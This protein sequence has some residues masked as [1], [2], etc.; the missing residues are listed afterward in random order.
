MKVLKVDRECIEVKDNIR[1][2]MQ[3]NSIKKLAESISEHG[4][5]QPLLV[6]ETGKGSYELIA[7]H[8]RLAAADD[9]S[10]REIP[11]LVQAIDDDKRTEIQL[12]E[13]LQREDLN[14]IDEALA[15]KELGEDYKEKDIVVMTGKPLYH[16]RQTK[17]LMELCTDVQN[18]IR[19]G[20]LSATHGYVVARLS[21][22]V[23]QKKLAS[24]IIKEHLSPRQAESELRDYTMSLKEVA[25]DTVDCKKCS[26]NSEKITDLFDDDSFYNANCLN[27]PCF[28]KKM[29]EHITKQTKDYTDKGYNVRCLPLGDRLYMNSFGEGSCIQ[30]KSYELKDYFKKKEFNKECLNGCDSYV[31]V[32]D[33]FGKAI[34]CCLNEACSKRKVKAMK[35]AVASTK[36]GEKGLEL[37]DRKDEL[38]K[39][40]KMNRVDRFKREFFI[41]QL[42]ER[43]TDLQLLRLTVHQLME[44]EPSSSTTLSDMFE[45]SDEANYLMRDIDRI[46]DM[47]ETSLLQCMRFLIEG[48]FKQYSTKELE[49]MGKESGANIV[50][51]FEVTKEY[52]E[53]LG[54]EDLTK[55]CKEFAVQTK[56]EDLEA[57]GRRKKTDMI[58]IIM[59]GDIKGKVPKEMT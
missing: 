36:A 5:L 19:Q 40:K 1:T 45:L 34:Q 7:G 28:R 47:D 54:K 13:N 18:F 44:S 53:K 32:I 22:P 50:K 48:R 52:L 2:T 42:E 23:S 59:A 15:Y 9:I 6:R 51:D 24:Q 57:F 12:V 35:H 39:V 29:K 3:K 10:L 25:F 20:K 26:F 49:S 33:G 17:M 56:K 37:G 4:I 43:L 41:P 8:R 11:V 21:N 27:E 58:D 38:K 55:L 16:I 46:K 14:P 31:I 30:L